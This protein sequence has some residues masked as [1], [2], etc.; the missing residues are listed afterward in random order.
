MTFYDQKCFRRLLAMNG[1][2]VVTERF[3][4]L[5]ASRLYLECS[6]MKERFTKRDTF[7]PRPGPAVHRVLFCVAAHGFVRRIT[8]RFEMTST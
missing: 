6:R 2:A 3:F 4:S 1:T 8:D 7:L 5:S